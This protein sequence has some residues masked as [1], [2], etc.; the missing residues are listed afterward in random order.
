M[1]FATVVG[2][3]PQLVKL[4]AVSRALRSAHTEVIIHTGQHYDFEMSGVFL[5]DL[6][7]P[8]PDHNLDAGSGSHA[9]QTARMLIGLERVL[10]LERPDCVVVFGDTNS[11]L[12]GAL[13]AAKMGIPVAHVEAGLRSFVR[14]M[15]EEINRVVSDHVSSHLFCPTA[16]AVRN[17][18]CE[19]LTRGVSLVGDV[20]LDVVNHFGPRARSRIIEERALAPQGYLLA[21]I[22]RAATADS[23]AA[24]A[25]L[26]AAFAAIDEPIVFPVH[27]RTRRAL[28]AAG[29]EP[30]SNVL[31]IDPVGYLEMLA[32][33]RGARL[34]LTDSGGVQKEAYF[35]GVP[36]ITLRNETEWV[37]LVEAGWNV[38]AG[39][40]APRI[41]GLVRDWSAAGERPPLFGHG[42]AAV[43]IA[44]AL[45]AAPR[46]GESR[47]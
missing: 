24:L 30:A 13:A 46:V 12:A 22:H 37:E 18:E 42:D 10:T 43:R 45:T 31:M 44:A 6:G 16:M 21:T 38:L 1:K 28:A 2:A 14:D 27:P 36:C 39:T 23:P 26:L 8:A 20:M 4:F 33:E 35:L 19:G 40:D 32:L 29:L 3:R 15:P 5:Q 11:T 41:A 47:T 9:G 25:G 17:L 34:I 7:L